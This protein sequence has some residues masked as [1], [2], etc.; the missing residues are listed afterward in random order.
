M[1]VLFCSPY[2]DSKEYAG[3]GITQWGKYIVS[4][5]KTEGR[6]DDIE[7]IPVSFD[8]HQLIT[9]GTTLISRI[10]WGIKD[11]CRSIMTAIGCMRDEKPEVIHICTSA[12]LG[13][14]KDLVLLYVAKQRK[15]KSVL[16]LH[17]GRV[18]E[19]IKQDKW[20]WKLLKI[21]FQLADR[22]V[23]MN[24][25]IYIAVK[26]QKLCDI[27][28]LP[29]PLDLSIV[30]LAEKLKLE[31]KREPRRLIFV[32]HV[33]KTKGVVE[34]VE[35]CSALNN[36]QLRIIGKYDAEMKN[37][38][39]RIA[40][41]KDSG[42]WLE[43]LGEVS[44]ELVIR[45]LLEADILVFPS[46]SEG[47]PNVILEAMVCGC[48]IAS[49]NV[50]AIPEM[51]DVENDACGVCFAPRDTMAVQKAVTKLLESPELKECMVSKAYKRVMSQY[52]MPMVWKQL[53][54]VWQG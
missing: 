51:L 6:K 23:A 7:L 25:P 4:Y 49:S 43:M 5:W 32:G 21:A 17:F 2:V 11:Q 10:R 42:C 28:Y 36:I 31:V 13:L 33:Y 40:R 20:E 18:P 3:G 19:I 38:L 27:R 41:A 53:V 1:K 14:L 46:Y 34:L 45:E 22:V 39:F 44:H 16:H 37:E 47:F 29:N 54:N 35:A 48:A 30:T 26:E 15:V 9:E 52:S 8:R 12:S 24:R 50:G